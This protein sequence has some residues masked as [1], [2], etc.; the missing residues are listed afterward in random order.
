MRADSLPS[1]RVAQDNFIIRY[2]QDYHVMVHQ[3]VQLDH[4]QCEREA[5]QFRHASKLPESRLQP[6]RTIVLLQSLRQLRGWRSDSC[7]SF[8]EDCQLS[9]FG[10]KAQLS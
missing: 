8:G 1:E 3:E 2:F 10:G 6:R 4:S 5:L 7:G 9:L